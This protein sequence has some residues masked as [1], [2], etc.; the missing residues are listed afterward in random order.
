M[1]QE[2]KIAPRSPGRYALKTT[3]SGEA[4]EKL[5]RLQALLSHAIPD[6][7]AG[8]IV[9]RAL[10]E[11]L[12]KT[13]KQRAA[14]VKRPRK[15]VTDVEAS[16]AS[17]TIPAPVQ[18]CVWERDGAACAFVSGDGHRCNETR[19]LEMHHEKPFARGGLATV[20]NISLRCRAH[21]RLEADRDYGALFMASKI[22]PPPS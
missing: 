7:D 17:R 20:D 15:Q 3:L 6:G 18:R 4:Y 13:L 11:L 22:R 8:A 21:N 10:D 5:V 9:E 19:F 16:E 2:T 12:E 1:Q 14:Q